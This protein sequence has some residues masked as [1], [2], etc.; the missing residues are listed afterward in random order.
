MRRRNVRFWP[1]A[2]IFS[3]TAHVRSGVKRTCLLRRKCLLLTQSADIDICVSEPCGNQTHR[4][5]RQLSA[6]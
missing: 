4:E 3:C 6:L 2:D 1:I 5:P